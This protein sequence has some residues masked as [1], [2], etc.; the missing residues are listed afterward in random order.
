MQNVSEIS[1]LFLRPMQGRA[2]GKEEPHTLERIE[3]SQT[4]LFVHFYH[5]TLFLLVYVMILCT[6]ILL[7]NQ[8]R[9]KINFS[10][11]LQIFVAV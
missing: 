4:K 3:V 6:L 1:A 7:L 2:H 11:I 9:F 5:E 10:R 8:V